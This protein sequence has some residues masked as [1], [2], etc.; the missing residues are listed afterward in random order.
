MLR[1]VRR[2]DSTKHI[3]HTCIGVELREALGNTCNL[4]MMAYTCIISCWSVCLSVCLTPDQVKAYSRNIV[5]FAKRCPVILSVYNVQVEQDL[6]MGIDAAGEAI[7]DPLRNMMPCLFDRN[8]RSVGYLY[9]HVHNYSARKR[10]C[11][12]LQLMPVQGGSP[13]CTCTGLF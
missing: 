9:R 13:T 3:V 7:S 6:A 4:L 1:K 10:L 12:T 8:I 2:Q 5:Y 11:C